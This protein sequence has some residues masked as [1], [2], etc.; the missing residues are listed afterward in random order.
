MQPASNIKTPQPLS[1]WPIS[2][3]RN[4]CGVLTDIDDTLTSQ[5]EITPEAL[6]AL[7]ILEKSN[8][9]VIAITGRP[10]GWSENFALTWPITC[11]VAENG[12]VALWA[13]NKKPKKA[14][15]QDHVT[16]AVNKQRLEFVSQLI[17][18][19]FPHATLA[20]DSAGRETDIAIDHSEFSKLSPS[21]IESIAQLMRHHGLTATVSS[22]HINGWIGNH[23]KW[24]GACWAADLLINSQLENTKDQWVFI[25]DSSNDA[26]M[27]EQISNS[28]GV[29]NIIDFLPKLVH[30][31]R[32][33]TPSPRGA[34]FAEMT[35]S[36]LS[37]R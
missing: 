16:R 5:G 23:N 8:I 28:F 37:I 13:E 31:P 36:L 32:Y 7:E 21:E 35:T 10:A 17:K 33:I 12:A 1:T 30:Q 9:P 2:D 24:T 15:A 27:F 18:K 26:C 22:I 34:G 3:R 4:I 19:Q 29:A 20:Q 6:A 25:G 11:I 14:W